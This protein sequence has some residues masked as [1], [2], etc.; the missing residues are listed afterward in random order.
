MT[1]IARALRSSLESAAVDADMT[2]VAAVTAAEHR[3]SEAA[4]DPAFDETPDATRNR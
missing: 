2:A 4:P 3:A 1:F